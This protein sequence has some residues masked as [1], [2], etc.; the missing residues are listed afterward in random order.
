MLL[1]CTPGHNIETDHKGA[2]PCALCGTGDKRKFVRGQ[3]IFHCTQ[4]SVYS[5]LK[6][7]NDEQ[8]LCC[9]DEW[10]KKRVLLSRYYAKTRNQRKRARE[11]EQEI[12]G[13]DVAPTKKIKECDF[14]SEIL[15]ELIESA[16]S[17]QGEKYTTNTA[18]DE[19]EQGS[20]SESS[21]S[22]NEFTSENESLK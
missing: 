11:T 17:V 16:S 5:C 7:R 13:D 8:G 6:K 1:M 19:D 15:N 10:H 20:N 12:V 18:G 4:C 21:S 9:F 14:I 22:S 3:S 2:R